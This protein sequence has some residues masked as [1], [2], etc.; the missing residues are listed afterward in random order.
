MLTLVFG[1]I[2]IQAEEY[3][4]AKIS[5]MK[6]DTALL[7]VELAGL[8]ALTAP[9]KMLAR[10]KEDIKNILSAFQTKLGNDPE[11]IAQLIME[12]SARYNINPFLILALIKTESDFRGHAVSNKGAIGLM[13]LKPVTARYVANEIEISFSGARDLKDGHMN[14][15]L[16]THYLA[17]L[18]DRFGNLKLALE[19][20]NR[21][22]SRLKKEMRN[23]SVMRFKYSN[24]VMGNYY[25]YLENFYYSS[26]Y[27][28]I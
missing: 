10:E 21:G 25:A 3:F 17:K 28:E 14:V 11:K 15:S 19:A 18:I 27:E 8:E 16:G 9:A 5:D 12:K 13:Q 20:Y 24:R 2:S 6:K 4:Q 22:P 26:L 23:G 1:I 7:R